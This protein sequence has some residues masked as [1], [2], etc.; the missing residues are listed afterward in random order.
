M[1]EP[2]TP[3]PSSWASVD[4]TCIYCE[5]LVAMQVVAKTFVIRCPKCGRVWRNP[6]EYARVTSAVLPRPALQ[7]VVQ[8]MNS[9]IRAGGGTPGSGEF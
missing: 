9:T 8:R 7:A 4:A 2:L 3:S 6:E 1:S 5:T